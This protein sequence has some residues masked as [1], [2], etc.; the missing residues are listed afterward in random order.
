M[1]KKCAKSQ[2]NEIKQ[3]FN[4]KKICI[5]QEKVVLLRQILVAN[6]KNLT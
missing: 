1:S 3:H 5:Y 6:H 4:R 2:K